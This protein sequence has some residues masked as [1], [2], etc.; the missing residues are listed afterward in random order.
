MC[1]T[2]TIVLFLLQ[3]T[4]KNHQT[5]VGIRF[6]LPVERMYYQNPSNAL[7][8]MERLNMCV[9]LFEVVKYKTKNYLS[10]ADDHKIENVVIPPILRHCVGPTAWFQSI[11]YRINYS[12]FHSQQGAP[13][14]TLFGFKC[15]SLGTICNHI[16]GA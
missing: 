16:I 3:L 8:L 15:S 7:E 14:C 5:Q 6:C 1:A 2:C 13:I 11:S 9:R 10:S 12:I 4:K